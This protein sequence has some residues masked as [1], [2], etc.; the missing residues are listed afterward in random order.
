[1]IDGVQAIVTKLL[2]EPS[3]VGLVGSRIYPVSLPQ[4][5]GVWPAIRVYRSGG[6]L[7][8]ADDGEVGLNNPRLSVEAYATTYSDAKGV[9]AA[10]A[11]VLSAFEGVVTGG[12]I[13]YCMLEDERDDREGGANTADYPFTVSQSYNLW[14]GVTQP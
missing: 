3:V 5:G 13:L 11:G 9:A 10:V 12:E 8:Y 4:A 1:M 6:E 7:L 2:S 14:I